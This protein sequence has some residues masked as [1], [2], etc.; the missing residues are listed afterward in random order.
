VI[1]EVE[2]VAGSTKKVE[3]LDAPAFLDFFEVILIPSSILKH[4]L[5]SSHTTKN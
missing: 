4:L 1:N 5:S 2:V 3:V